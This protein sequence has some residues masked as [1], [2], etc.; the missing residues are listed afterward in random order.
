MSKIR[1]RNWL[2][3]I[4]V[5][6]VVVSGIGF[7]LSIHQQLSFPSC[8]YEGEVY[9]N[10]ENVPNYNG[11]DNCTCGSTGSIMCNEEDQSS[12]TG[13]SGF[14]SSNL[15]FT[16][17]FLNLLSKSTTMK[18]DV[19]TS[20]ASY[21]DNTMSITIERNV[22]CSSDNSAPVQTG[23]YKLSSS[24]L[25]LVILTST[26]SVKYTEPCRV[27]AKFVISDVNTTLSDNFQIYYQSEGGLTANLGACVYNGILYGSQEAFK[28]QDSQSVCLCNAGKIT[29][30]DLQ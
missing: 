29:C 28:S 6:L 11:K 5:L 9:K 14:S 17:R 24:E 26:D 10:G 1:Q 23:F 4:T 19:D 12:E 15:Q 20:S 22:L 2:I 13:L 30:R 8:A 25:N 27:E 18:E 21:S 7:Y 3:I 16:Y